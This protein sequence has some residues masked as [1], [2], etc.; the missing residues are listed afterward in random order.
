[1][2]LMV[3]VPLAG[4]GLLQGTAPAAPMVSNPLPVPVPVVSP[5]VAPP[6]ETPPPSV[7]SQAELLSQYVDKVR[8]RLRGQMVYKGRQGNPEV[9]FEVTLA[10]DMHVLKVKKLQASNNLMFDR[11]VQKAITKMGSYPALPDGL[12]FSMF[13]TH[14]IKYRLHD[15]L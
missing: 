11:A 4:C 10:P 1:M 5:A 2:L 9:L 7:V 14:K 13:S 3:L 8:R 15:L 12:D 6:I